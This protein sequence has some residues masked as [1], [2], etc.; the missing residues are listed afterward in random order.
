MSS[1]ISRAH[2]TSSAETLKMTFCTN[3]LRTKLM[4]SL[5]MMTLTVSR[6]GGLVVAK[7]R[8]SSSKSLPSRS[9]LSSPKM[10]T[11]SGPSIHSST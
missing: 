1:T 8:S 10:S 9:S 7:S 6:C 4:S 3:P 5:S 2:E 11:H